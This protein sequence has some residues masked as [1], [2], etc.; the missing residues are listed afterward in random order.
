MAIFESIIFA[1]VAAL[2]SLKAIL[3]AAAA[4]LF[5]YSLSARIRKRKTALRRSSPGHPRLD[6]WA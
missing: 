4:V 1:I 6:L 5:V 3:L 2:V